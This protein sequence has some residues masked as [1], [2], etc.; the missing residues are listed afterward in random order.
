MD[1]HNAQTN[2]Y[3]RNFGY[4]LELVL[5]TTCSHL[6]KNKACQ[7]ILSLYEN[8]SGLSMHRNCVSLRFKSKSQAILNSDVVA[9]RFGLSF[10]NNRF[11]SSQSTNSPEFLIDGVSLLTQFKAP[12][13]FRIMISLVYL[14]LP[15]AGTLWCLNGYPERKHIS[16]TVSTGSPAK[17]V[18]W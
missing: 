13:V 11:H 14:E 8:E 5:W 4:R 17:T 16:N 15:M 1:I 12:L 18:T 6:V 10:F 2:T 9:N 7:T 3:R